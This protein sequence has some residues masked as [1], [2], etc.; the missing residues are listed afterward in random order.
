MSEGLL[1]WNKSKTASLFSFLLGHLKYGSIF[2]KKPQFL[3]S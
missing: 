2:E 3:K 1:K